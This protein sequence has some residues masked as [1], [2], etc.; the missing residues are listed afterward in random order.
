MDFKELN[1]V[2]TIAREGSISGAAEK[3]FMAQSSLSQALQN[4]ETE[5]GTSLFMRTRRGVR[6]TASGE[7]FIV[8]AEQIIQH[9]R[10]AQS[11]VWDIEGL[12]GGRVEFGLSSFRGSYLLPPVLR[13]FHELY[14]KVHVNIFEENSVELEEMILDGLI[15]IALIAEPQ[16]RIRQHTEYLMDDEILLVTTANHP[17]MEFARPL[18]DAGKSDVRHWID[19]ADTAPF[20][21][22]LSPQDTV[23]GRM[24]RRELRKCGVEPQG[25]NANLTA[26]FAA[27]MAREG[28]GLAVTYRSCVVRDENARYLRLGP[29]GVF[30]ELSLAYPA[31]E[32]RSKAARTLAALLHDFYGPRRDAARRE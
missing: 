11:E 1:Y 4:F 31:G 27:A 15:D 32:Y 8:R 17:V 16:P 21:Y 24:A 26:A 7:A 9:G 22:I 19:L 2:V 12:K 28:I 25:M 10:R 23:L 18:D 13:R 29:K 20:E 3:L 14:P 5:L 6:P 30:L